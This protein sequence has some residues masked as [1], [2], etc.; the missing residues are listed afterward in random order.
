MRNIDPKTFF[1][2]YLYYL[3]LISIF[4]GFLTIFES[5]RAFLKYGHFLTKLLK[6]SKL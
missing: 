2:Y 4:G 3:M 1:F 5:F 6:I